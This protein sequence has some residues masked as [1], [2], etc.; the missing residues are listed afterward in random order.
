VVGVAEVRVRSVPSGAR[1][2]VLLTGATAASIV[3]NYVFLLAAGRVL[4][5][6]EYGSLAAL[7]GLLSVV[8]IPAS[9]LQMAVSR[10]I[11]RR[12]ASGDEGG[13]TAFARATFRIALVATIPLMVVALALAAPLSSLLHIDSVG[14]VLLAE[15]TL[16][17]A[18]VFPVALG[19]LQGLQRFHALAANYVFPLF[20]RLVL[21]AVLASAG[22]RL[23]GAVVAA[24]V[25]AVAGTALSMAL[26]RDP[27]RGA[28]V[29]A[30]P[31][32]RSFFAYLGPVA[33][34]LVGIALLT[35]VDI[36]VVKARFS[37]DEAGAYG[38][39]SAFARVA[40]FLPTTILA[41]LFPRTAAR[42]ARGEETAD[43]LGR[44]LIATAGFC[45]LLAL[46]YEAAGPG[47]VTTTFGSD[48][49]AG[50]DILAPFALAIGLF[51]LA[52]ILVGYHLSR[53]ETRYAWIVA[54]G[55]IAQVVV[56]AV[57][58]SSLNAVVWTNVIIGAVLLATHEVVI[59]SSVPALRAGFETFTRSVDLRVRSIA[60]EGGPVVLGLTAFVCVL[61]LPMVT[62]LGSTII[63]R[64][65][66]ATGTVWMFWTWQHEGGYHLFG[67]THH[68]LTGAPFGWDG[69]N[70]LNIQWLL[71]YYPAY[72]LT[73]VF[74]AVAAQNLVLISGYV[75]SGAAMY[76]FVRYLG[77]GRLVGL[78]AALVYIVFPAH[79]ERTPHASL[80]HLEFFPLLLLACLAAA[81][82]PTWSRIG[83]VGLVTLACWLTSGYFG[84]MA[85]ITT[86]AFGL[87]VVLT[88]AGPRTWR[89]LIATTGTA[90]VATLLVAFLSALSGVGR[91]SGLHRIAGDLTFYGLRP[92]ELVVP[93]ARNF[94][95]GQ[96]TKPFL[97]ARQHLSNPTET[98]NYLGL[99]TLVLAAAWIVFAWRHRAR[100]A[101]RLSLATSG[102]V[103]V[104]VVSFLLALPS[105]V[106][107]FGHDFWMPSRV[108]WTVLPPFRVPSR[109][110]VILITALIALGAL[111]L[112]E[113]ATRAAVRNRFAPVVIVVAAMVISFLELGENPNQN[114]F[115]TSDEPPEYA[116]I[117][118]TPPGLV[119]DYPLY[120]DTDRLFWQ[121][122]FHRPV[123]VSEAFGAAPD[124]A[125]RA[126]VNPSTPGAAA[127][128]ALLGVTSIV[129]HPDA[130]GYVLGVPNVPNASWGPGYRLVARTPDGS[131]TWEVVAKPAVALVTP[132]GLGGPTPLPGNVPGYPLLSSSGVGYI[133]IRTRHAGVIKL[134]FTATPPLH[135]YK[136][137]RVADATKELPI[138]LEGPFRVS[139]FVA[140]P[141]GFS[142]VALKTDPA[143]KSRA[144]AIVMSDMYA[145][146][147][148][149]KP[150]LEAI[151]E[152]ANPGF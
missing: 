17:T 73:T 124:E 16:S 126:L 45:G 115:S 75:L 27:L 42:Q 38:A 72:L 65:S 29:L 35:H 93:T 117:A 74:G 98:S 106:T 116:A 39:A 152:S 33:V 60:A 132:T 20:V 147:T 145:E 84:A 87:G 23:G 105:P 104:G 127:Q 66:D 123:I 69:D 32:L 63:G 8:L 112:Q 101:E 49:A 121:I 70:G 103:A 24:L 90:L 55:V 102:L 139:V 48:F 40:F 129:T 95:F 150:Q 57:V 15:C 88:R 62:S 10:E 4:G 134:T 77:C 2:G 99:L 144:D 59:G 122:R 83:L 100:L 135:V 107:I 108:L 138:N 14:I 68:T 52:N 51:S 30:R 1:S 86:T 44:S 114:R 25:G 9:A 109:W 6:E 76:A 94:V 50:G 47:L 36:L 130:L 125:R 43:I 136:R 12:I 119:A 5:S 22:Y 46:F 128:L 141:R 96:W 81:R 67:Q 85:L 80:T 151:P 143:P 148:S 13:A 133:G 146:P 118:R 3:A 113:V 120:Q 21:F 79:L 19:V 7:L 61:F 28:A 97:Y 140:V 89:M 91:G 31:E 56:L 149:G 34:G 54:A 78:W 37:G 137:L 110:V 111:A 142:L 26:I 11:S 58:P 131:S 53:G 71:V 64:G 92:I 18:L 82:N 41:V